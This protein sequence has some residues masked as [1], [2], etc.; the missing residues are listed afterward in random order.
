MKRHILSVGILVANALGLIARADLPSYPQLPTERGYGMVDAFISGANANDDVGI[1]R[2]DSEYRTGANGPSHRLDGNYNGHIVKISKP[3]NFPYAFVPDYLWATESYNN[4]IK[5]KVG[6]FTPGASYLFQHYVAETWHGTPGENR[7]FKIYAN[8]NNL[9]NVNWAADAGETVVIPTLFPLT[10][11]V[12]ECVVQADDEGKIEMSFVGVSDNA[13]Y[14]GFSVWGTS[15]PRWTD[16]SI[17]G[18]GA[19]VEMSWSNPYDVLR[20]YVYSADS[21]DGPWTEVEVL[22]PGITTYTISGAYNPSV[23]KYWRVVASNGVGK[24]TC[25]AKLGDAS[26]VT[27]TD[28]ATLGETVASDATANYRVATAGT[29]AVNALGAT[30]TEAAM[31]VNGYTDAHTLAIGSGETLKVGTLGVLSGAGDM[32]VGG[33]VGQGAVSPLSGTLTFDVKDA[34]STLTVNAAATKTAN[35]DSIVKFGAGAAK[36][37]GG[38]DITSVSIGAGSVDLPNTAAATLAQTLSG[39]GT[40]VKSGAGTL[41]V[42]NENPN[43]AGTFEVKE[44]T[45]LIGRTDAYKSFGDGAATIKVDAG[46]TLDVGMPDA[47]GNAVG[48]RATKV[49]FE[50]TGDNEKGALINSST[51]SQY[52]ALVCGEMSGDATVVS[53]GRFDF[54][55]TVSG[56]YF[57]MNGHVLTK[58]GDNS[59]LF[60]SVPVNA[61]GDTAKIRIEQGT[62]GVESGTTFNGNGTIEFAGGAFDVYNLGSPLTWPVTVTS[63]G[64][65]FVC[66]SGSATQN[67]IAGTVTIEEGAELKLSPNDNTNFRITGKITGPGKL[68]RD[69]GGDAGYARIENKENDWTGGTE[70]RKGVLYCPCAAVL[71]GYNVAGKVVI[72]G[73]GKIAVKLG[74]GGDDGWSAEQI[75]ALMANADAP[76]GAKGSIMIDT[77]GYDAASGTGMVNKP[78]GIAKTGDGTFTAEMEYTAGGGIYADQGTLVISNNA[79]NT[80]TSLQVVKKGRVEIYDSEI[81]FGNN[82]LNIGNVRSDGD[83]PTVVVGKGA[84][85]HSDM[86][87]NLQGSPSLSLGSG[88]VAGGILEVQDGGIVSNKLFM[89]N[90]QY[91]QSAILQSGGE[92][93][94]W[95]GPGSDSVLAN[96]QWTWGYWEVAGTGSSTFTGYSQFAK[97]PNA[98]ATIA[99]RD[100]G[101]VLVTNVLNGSLTMSRGGHGAIDQSGGTF[102]TVGGFIMGEN[103]IDNNGVGGTGVY[104]MRGGTANIGGA[105]GASIVIADRPSFFGQVNFIDGEL[106]AKDL[107]RN[108]KDSPNKAY[109]TF[110]GGTFRAKQDGAALF[111]MD[112]GYKLDGAYVYEKGAAFDTD[113]HNVTLGQALRAPTGQGVKAIAW[114][115]TDAAKLKWKGTELMGPPMVIIEGDGEGATAVVDFDTA[116]RRVKGIIVTSPGWGYTEK[117]T[118]KLFGGGLYVDN[119]TQTYTIDASAVIMGESSAGQIVKKGAGTLTLEGANGVAGAEVRGGTL[120]VPAGAS[121]QPGKLTLAGGTFSAP[122]YTA[123]EFIVNGGEDDVSTLD[124]VL[125]I[126]GERGSLRQPGLYAAF[127]NGDLETTF[128]ATADD[129][130]LV[131]TN[132]EYVQT[133]IPGNY[134]IFEDED[135]VNSNLNCAY[136]GYIW[137]RTGETVTWTFAEHFDDFVYLKIDD[138]VVLNDCE[139]NAWTRPTYGSVTLTPGPHRFHLVVYQGGGTSGPCVTEGWF[140]WWKHPDGGWTIG[141]DFQGRDEG[142]YENFVALEDPGDGSLFTLT[143]DDLDEE[144]FAPDAYVH[145]NGGTLKL[146]ASTPGLYGGFVANGTYATAACPRTGVYPSLDYAN[147]KHA[148][149]DEIDGYANKNIGYVFEGYIWNHGNE[150]VTWTFAENFDD[151]VYLTVDGAKVL[152]NGSYN[153]PTKANVTLSPGAHAIRIGLNQG[154]GGSGPSAGGWLTDNTIG[155]GIDFEGRDAEVPE[156]YVPLTATAHGGELPLLTTAPYLPDVQVLPAATSFAIANGAKVDLG[157]ANFTLTGDFYSAEGAFTNGTLAVSGDWTVDV[158]D[159]VEGRFL[160]GDSFD[161]SGAT[162]VLT[163]DMK[164]LDMTETYII[165]LAAESITGVPVV[166]GAPK[167]WFASIRGRKLVLRRN[168]GF[169]VSLR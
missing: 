55:N 114:S 92:I 87:P 142:V 4:S 128:T 14:G 25:Q 41:T 37:A 52:N 67:N 75:N 74:S 38:T 8:T 98:F 136:D 93:V 70:V 119:N 48:L 80:M 164:L 86:A 95:C 15:A 132:L 90:N 3:E 141:V 59:F 162:L 106:A 102:E 104:E 148:E 33:T 46:A 159:L 99:I 58:K 53:T 81:D 169:R 131:V 19:N 115:Q 31:Y 124:T 134:K 35:T 151:N 24:V 78:I 23:E 133:S 88:D 137:N 72:S 29:G 113:G 122:S 82:N 5:V 107:Y 129:H 40:F 63:A 111:G 116:T 18:S 146:M 44:G 138:Q 84:Y 27:W 165:A 161:F 50:G 51:T 157:G 71:P 21:A 167:G 28:L 156:N 127:K 76:E 34:A 7:K 30:T 152:D 2:S 105:N 158:A 83:I 11:L 130:L 73:T 6:G 66:R 64:G 49:V 89:G 103:S 160:R 12:S 125:S 163:G 168:L 155:I 9:S 57:N 36:L 56:S 20:Y 153:T 22:K 96:A 118:V 112:E 145:V 61:G 117:P 166:E 42:A 13:T 147:V 91:S 140:Q 150:A 45:L 97:N 62:L 144:D 39:A 10:P 47:G 60:T 108:P 43:F 143:T 139:Q 109:A 101:S 123:T 77:A 26:A 126:S 85:I 135:Y 100:N 17:V 79:A 65:K 120:S 1:F 94:N 154:T 149:T 16:P 32:T 69:E 121:I 110:N 54:R 68:V